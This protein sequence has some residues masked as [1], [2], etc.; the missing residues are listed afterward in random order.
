MKQLTMKI[1]CGQCLWIIRWLNSSSNIDYNPFDDLPDDDDAIYFIESSEHKPNIDHLGFC[2]I[3]SAAIHNPDKQIHLLINRHNPFIRMSGKKIS[4]CFLF[5]Y[6]RIIC[7][8]FFPLDFPSFLQ[9]LKSFSLYSSDLAGMINFHFPEWTPEVQGR[10]HKR[11]VSISEVARAVVLFY[12]G[13]I[14]LDQDAVSI[15]PFSNVRPNF[16]PMVLFRRVNNAVMKFERFNP[17]LKLALDVMV[18]HDFEGF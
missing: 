4:H 1:L 9:N 17:T 7:K 3:E 16:L 12:K 15:R 10:F 8:R 18:G 14:Y 5:R 2:A 6:C 13:G 11:V